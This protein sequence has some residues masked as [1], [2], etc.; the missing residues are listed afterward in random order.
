MV[1]K[2]L[3]IFLMGTL[4]VAAAATGTSFPVLLLMGSL[5]LLALYATPARDERQ[6]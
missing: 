1:R 5:I 2:T 3:I 6:E 4:L